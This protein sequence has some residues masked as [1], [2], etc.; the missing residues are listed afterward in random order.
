MPLQ[1]CFDDCESLVKDFLCLLHRKRV[2]FS[3]YLVRRVIKKA[4]CQNFA[5]SLVKNPFIDEVLDFC[6]RAMEAF[7]IYA[8]IHPPF[9]IAREFR[10]W[11]CPIQ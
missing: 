8:H 5:I 9:C 1:F 10:A 3:E 4:F 7:S 11:H 2:F 6:A